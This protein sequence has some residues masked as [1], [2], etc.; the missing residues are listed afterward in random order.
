[1]SVSALALVCRLFGLCPAKANFKVSEQQASMRASDR[2]RPLDVVVVVVV[3]VVVIFVFVWRQNSRRRRRCSGR[4]SNV[5]VSNLE[6][7]SSQKA[8]PVLVS[9]KTMTTCCSRCTVRLVGPRR[10]VGQ[11]V[12]Q[13]LWRRQRR[14]SICAHENLPR[15]AHDFKN[16][17]LS[18]CPSRQFDKA[19]GKV[20]QNTAV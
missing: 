3:V 12:C 6:I 20:V 18:P 11:F 2:E 19:T 7:N 1:M 8:S 16:S 9:A 13:F 5:I 10:H 4:L 17:S 14:R 15:E